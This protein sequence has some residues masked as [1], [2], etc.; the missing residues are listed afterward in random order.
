VGH[1][2]GTLVADAVHGLEL[3]R[4]NVLSTRRLPGRA[5]VPVQLVVPLR[6]RYVTPAW[7][8]A[9]LAHAEPV[10]R[11]TLD[12]G[13]W[14]ALITHGVTLADW[15]AHFARHVDGGPADREL[16]AARVVQPA[17]AQPSTPTK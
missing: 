1:P 17:V 16:R 2:A 12:T 11:R 14:G 13:H 3:Y 8:D 5:R 9:A 10:W 15:I 4:A 7:A 6:D